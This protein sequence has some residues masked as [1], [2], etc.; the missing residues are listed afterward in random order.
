MSRAQR[1]KGGKD[2]C[3]SGAFLRLP[4]SVL[5]SRAYLDA[6]PHARMLLLDLAAQY[7]GD[8]N[9]DLAASWTLMQRRGWRSKETLTA[10]KREL[11]ALEL[12]VETRM[13]ARPN[14]ASLYACTWWALDECG[15]KLELLPKHFPRGAY[16]LRDPVP[17][18]GRKIAALSPVAVPRPP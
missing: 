10:A 8:N 1:Y 16:R 2:K 6:G 12:I 3:D 17:Q 14:K 9:G 18:P 5:N 13:G 7:K 15:G 11:I 4:L